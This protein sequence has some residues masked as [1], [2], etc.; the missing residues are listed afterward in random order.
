MGIC[1][2]HT[3][4]DSGFCLP[5]RENEFIFLDALRV[6]VSS[7]IGKFCFP[8][9]RVIDLSLSLLTTAYS[10]SLSCVGSFEEIH[11]NYRIVLGIFVLDGNRICSHGFAEW[12]RVGADEGSWPA[13]AA[14]AADRR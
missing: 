13:A 8:A 6:S 10:F 1:A 14:E 5:H 2:Q 12:K 7:S 3:R 9:S 4:Q 11:K